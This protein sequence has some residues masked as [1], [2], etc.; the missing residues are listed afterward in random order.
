VIKFLVGARDVYLLCNIQTDSGAYQAFYTMVTR[1]YFHGV[2]WQGCEVYHSSPS[3]DEVK[4]YDAVL[5]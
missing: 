4:N 1:N 5:N 2:K 3:S